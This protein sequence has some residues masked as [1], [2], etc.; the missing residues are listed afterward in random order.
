MYC[1]RR[2]CRR[3][4]ASNIVTNNLTINLLVDLIHELVKQEGQ[5][6][7]LL[8]AAVIIAV[9]STLGL[10]IM[11]VRGSSMM[12]GIPCLVALP[13]PPGPCGLKKEKCLLSGRV[14]VVVDRKRLVWTSLVKR[15][16]RLSKDDLPSGRTREEGGGVPGTRNCTVTTANMKE[17]ISTRQDTAM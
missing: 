14:G 11:V 8:M 13:P 10:G 6:S 16:A 9:S 1:R 4:H 7:S 17:S 2:C 15:A 5:P 12:L 3:R